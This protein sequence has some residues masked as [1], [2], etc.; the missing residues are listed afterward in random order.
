MVFVRP[1]THGKSRM[2]PGAKNTHFYRELEATI[3]E[4]G[5]MFNAHL[6]LDRYGTLEDRYTADAQHQILANSHVSLQ[7]KHHLINAIHGG[8]AYDTSD[9]R[10]RVNEALDTMVACNTR[11]ADT[12]VD[13]T[14]DRVGLTALQTM[15][16]IKHTRAHEIDLRLAA[17]T[18]LG[19]RDD[20]PERWEV[21]EEGARQADFI[22][23]LP[24]VDELDDYPDNIG[25][26]ENCRR[27]IRLARELGR[28]LQVH[29]D[30][31]NEPG[32][33]GTER[34]LEVLRTE[35]GYT[36]DSPVPAVWAIHV[37]SPTAYDQE[38]FDALVDGLL[39]QNVGVIVCPSAAIGMRQLRPLMTP[40]A[41]SITRVLELLAR[42]VH[43]RL[44][45]DN[46]ADICSPSTTADLVDEVF[47]LSAAVRYYR[48]DVLAQLAA[49]LRLTGDQLQAV[50]EHLEKNEREIARALGAEIAGSAP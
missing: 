46:I 7:K 9:L 15:L 12:L 33:R 30:Q 41:N 5:G 26:E 49:G 35:G 37:I 22:A 48:I 25:Y 45:S 36:L 31:R 17:Y 6:H 50:Q 44:A 29:T 4:L 47:V 23:T 27:V 42:G 14:A 20:E 16:E 8:P 10:S 43:V 18:P 32:E 39:E 2:R 11:R 1:S 3:A 38:R 28:P 13:V 34:L 24:E 40:T 21:F 19:F